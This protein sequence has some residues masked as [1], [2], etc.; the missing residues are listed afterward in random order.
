MDFRVGEG[1]DIHPLRKGR[2]FRLGGVTLVH[3]DGLGPAGHSDGDPLLHAVIDAMLG[4]LALGDIGGWFPD[5][6]PRWKDAD[7]AELVRIVRRDPRLSRWTLG[8]LDAT[9]YLSRPK[10]APHLLELRQSLSELLEAPVERIS[11]KAK[12]MNGLGAIGCGD[13]VAARVCL[14]A[15]L[16]DGISTSSTRPPST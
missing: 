2:P 9:V 10:M 15:I 8:N 14:L 12:S 3:P 13:A 4:S 5:T 11:L 7:S 16:Q 1:F 6:A